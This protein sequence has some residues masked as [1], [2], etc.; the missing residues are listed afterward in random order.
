MKYLSGYSHDFIH[1]VGHSI[2][3]SHPGNYRD[4]IYENSAEYIEDSAQYTVMS[5]FGSHLTGGTFGMASSPPLIDDIGAIQRLYG[6]NMTTRTGD[7]V[8][9][10]NSTAD[11]DWFAASKD[12][13]ARPVIFC[14]WDAGGNDTLDFSGYSDTQLIDL[15]AERFSNVGG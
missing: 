12:G 15:N 11:R 5:Y 1:E 9:G 14:V 3:L 13:V 8:Y 7:T 6:A 4:G 2:G 10:F